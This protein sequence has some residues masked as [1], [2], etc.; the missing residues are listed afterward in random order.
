MEVAILT[1]L[2]SA[3][4]CEWGLTPVQESVLTSAVFAGM[5]VGAPVWGA[6]S[7]ARGR[8]FA[9]G[10]GVLFTC[11]F[12]FASAAA[13]SYACLMAFRA[14]VGF[15]IPSTCVAFNWL[16]ECVPT[17]TRGFFLV[18]I[19][20]FWTVGTVA[21]AV[22]AYALL[23]R[24][25][26]RVMLAVS[27]IPSF[28]LLVLVPLVPES[29]RFLAVKGR[30]QEAEAV[31]ARMLRF[32]GQAPMA[33]RL[34]PLRAP[35]ARA[36]PMADGAAAALAWRAKGLASSAAGGLSGLF[37]RSLWLTTL[38]LVFVWMASTHVYVRLCFEPTGS[39]SRRP[40][41]G[42]RRVFE[43]KRRRRPATPN[44]PHPPHPPLPPPP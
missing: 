30:T 6:V 42:A 20:A 43:I 41:F 13:P 39:C 31:L 4:K 29:P 28:V 8:K 21:Q 19:E 15:G 38:V 5:C 17:S 9:F 1:Y 11:V 26:W 25:G 34:R 10:L 22:L 23:N 3:A 7:D 32:C 18:G 14:L 40:I 33:G 37:S 16:G 35:P 24:Y 2:A 44:A 12:G 27:A 36:P